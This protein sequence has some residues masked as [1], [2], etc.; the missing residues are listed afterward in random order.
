MPDCLKYQIIRAL[1]FD[2]PVFY[3]SL[4]NGIP[5]IRIAIREKFEIENYIYLANN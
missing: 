3:Y 5:D 2:S 1:S 4:V